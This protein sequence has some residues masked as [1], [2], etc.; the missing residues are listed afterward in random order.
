MPQKKIKYAPVAAD[1][2][3]EIFSY[4]SQENHLAAEALLNK[5]ND[6]I[7]ALADFPEMGTVLSDEDYELV[8]QGYRFIVVHPYLI[9]YRY[10]HNTVFIH[11]ILHGRRDYLRELFKME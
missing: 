2:M 11:R 9:F 3:D 6:R 10:N 7:I 8:K 1:D 4:I 5:L